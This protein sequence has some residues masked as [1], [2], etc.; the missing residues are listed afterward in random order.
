MHLLL[1]DLSKPTRSN[2]HAMS[3]LWKSELKGGF[4]VIRP[5]DRS[6][7]GVAYVLKTVS[8]SRAREIGR[9][10]ENGCAQ[11]TARL[12]R[13]VTHSLTGTTLS[14]CWNVSDAN[15]YEVAKIGKGQG[16]LGE[17]TVTLSTV[18]E[19]F[20]RGL[21]ADKETRSLTRRGITDKYRPWKR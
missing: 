13:E 20:I 10:L 11:E 12:E 19:T 21:V 15:A 16:S 18:L 14:D 1:A 3:W 8:A 2:C 7:S 9:K 17:S 6:L 5:F 4:S